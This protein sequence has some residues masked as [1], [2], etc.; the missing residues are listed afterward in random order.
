MEV[1][2]FR[3]SKKRES[4]LTPDSSSSLF[5][6]QDV[7]L[8]DKNT[9]L[10]TP[11]LRVTY[12]QTEA[13]PYTPIF[14]CN[15]CYIPLFGQRYYYIGDWSYNA[16]GTWT[17]SCTVDVLGSFKV[18]ISQSHGYLSRA[19]DPSYHNLAIMDTFYPA[20]NRPFTTSTKVSTTLTGQPALGTY[21]ISV[22][23]G[24]GQ[25]ESTTYGAVS[26]YFI[27]KAQLCKLLVDF[28]NTGS[29]DWSQVSDL[30]ND[31]L[32]SVINPF[33]YIVSCKLYPFP[34]SRL[35]QLSYTD[36][37]KLGYWTSHA[38]GAKAPMNEV[39]STVW[40]TFNADP[41]TGSEGTRVN[42]FPESYT[43]QEHAYNLPPYPP[44]AK[45]TLIHPVFGT[46]ELDPTIVKNYPYLKTV[47]DINFI[48]GYATFTVSALV[49][50][51]EVE[52]G[53]TPPPIFYEL[54]R[55]NFPIA[56]DVPLAQLTTEYMSMAKS[57]LSGIGNIAGIATGASVT[58]KIG[59][60]TGL[61]GNLLDAASAAIAP[62]VQTSTPPTGGFNVEVE[63]MTVLE[64][65][66][67]TIDPKPSEF[68]YP[69][70]KYVEGLPTAGYVLMDETEFMSGACTSQERELIC[71]FLTGSG[72]FMEGFSNA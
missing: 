40:I 66:F 62:S 24:L 59:A 19:A 34:P 30:G 60:A 51:E 46:F 52:E 63:N 68:G 56:I 65:R 29:A 48:S 39:L 44:Y 3:F 54:I 45:Y 35:G 6:L 70:K 47:T 17:A 67:A 25:N 53:Q 37:I 21:M 22:V 32:K 18:A 27:T 72:V 26:N 41:P 2:F 33:Q 23:S 71:E 10:M 69:V 16:D 57:T 61:A 8:N 4:T 15:Y 42:T 36:T 9:S 1:Y 14:L 5:H 50:Y 7:I 43:F 58:E 64:S 31:A 11:N 20:I 28:M 38:T 49:G 12:R 13:S 55:T